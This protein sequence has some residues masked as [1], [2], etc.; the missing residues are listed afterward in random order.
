MRIFWDKNHFFLEDSKNCEQPYLKNYKSENRFFI[1]FRSLRNIF[2]KK[3]CLFLR[4]WGHQLGK[5]KNKPYEK[6]NIMSKRIIYYYNYKV[7]KNN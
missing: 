5:P 1:R 4:G 7:F 3:N 6:N 2:D